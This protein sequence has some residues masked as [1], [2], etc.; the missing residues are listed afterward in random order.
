MRAPRTRR[1]PVAIA[2]SLMPAVESPPLLDHEH[3]RAGAAVGPDQVAGRLGAVA[4]EGNRFSHGRKRSPRPNW[5]ATPRP[6]VIVSHR[7]DSPSH[8]RGPLGPGMV[9]L[10]G[11]V[12]DLHPIVR[13]LRT[14]TGSATSTASARGSRTSP[15]S[16][17][18]RCGST[19]GIRRRRPTRATTSPT[20]ATSSRSSV[21]S[22]K[23]GR[24]IAEAH[25]A[26]IRVLLDIVPNHTSDEHVWFQAALASPPGSAERARYIFRPGTGEQ[27]RASHPTTG[28]RSSAARRGRA[29][30]SPTASGTC[31]CST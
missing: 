23:D 21:R 20:I 12:P 17:S 2:I 3:S 22:T 9:A 15:P 11:H 10:V 16:A 6:S 1:R 25:A 14:A 30:T 4:G 31:T 28:C 29:S 13:R 18:T 7:D 19:R 26:G 27:R 8:R 24:L 5:A